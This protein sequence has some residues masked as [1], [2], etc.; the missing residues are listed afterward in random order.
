MAA[1]SG[2]MGLRIRALLYCVFDKEEG[3]ILACSDP[4]SAL[5]RQQTKLGSYLLPEMFVKGRVVSVVV[6]DN[7]VLGAPVYIE[8]TA[9]DRNCFQF[10]ICVIISNMID[11]EPYRDLAQHLA[12]AFQALETQDKFLSRPDR[13]ETVREVLA[14]LRQQLTERGECF[15]RVNDSHCISFRVWPCGPL[16]PAQPKP[17]EVPVP[18][19]DL[20]TMLAPRHAALT[21]D[22]EPGLPFEP[23]L[24]LIHLVSYIDGAQT[25][26]ELA[27]ASGLDM[28]VVMICLQ[29]LVY[30]G[31]VKV[32]D[33]INL[34][35]RYR[36]T[37][38]FHQAFDSPGV[39]D[40]VVQY[41]TAG[42]KH[43]ESGDVEGDAFLNKVQGLYAKIDGWSQ[44]LGDFQKDHGSELQEREIS[45][46]HFIT[47]GLLR[48]F[49]ECSE[50][51]SPPIDEAAAETDMPFRWNNSIKSTPLGRVES[52]EDIN[53][54]LHSMKMLLAPA[55][56]EQLSDV[57]R[58][59]SSPLA[60]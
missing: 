15:V 16:L 46:R 43:F 21:K 55:S 44:T 34:K 2:Q 9:Y 10:N 1:A 5:P 31:L 23:D 49:L 29:H 32:I 27:Q 30:F 58:T 47:F 50:S 36:L 11:V 38:E 45:L 52:L 54:S 37:I 24:A 57:Q 26:D 3:P 20:R 41:V 28:E 7:V 35:S 8:D 60:E 42:R 12:S 22:T 40:E 39:K 56:R 14:E 48:G 51:E 33:A 53:V 6:D 18:L 17:S 13:V 19:A 59:E 4:P 25:V